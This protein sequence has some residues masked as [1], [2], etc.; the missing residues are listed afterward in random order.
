MISGYHNGHKIIYDNGWKYADT[1]EEITL[2]RPCPKCGQYQTP[3]GHDPCIENLPGVIN[4]CCGH[5]IKAGYL[6]F[7]D[8]RI[9]RCIFK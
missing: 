9:L 3:D 5:G 7:A 1:K 6:Q 4:A 8:G 2:P